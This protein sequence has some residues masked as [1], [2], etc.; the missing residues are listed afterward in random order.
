[1]HVFH[2]GNLEVAG[3]EGEAR[4]GRPC[5]KGRK[6]QPMQRFSCL[7][8]SGEEVGMAAWVGH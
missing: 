2:K 1:M 5:C 3:A 6:G 7:L 4:E 8:Q